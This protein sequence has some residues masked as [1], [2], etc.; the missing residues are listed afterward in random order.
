MTTTGRRATPTRGLV[1]GCGGTLG[2]AWTTGA[3]H[4][5][6]EALRWDPRDAD[7]V[8][9][10]SAGAELAAM[11]GSGIGVRD[12]LA[13]Q[14][15][16]EQA[17]PALLRHFATPPRGIPPRPAALLGSPRL[18][19]RALGG[20]LPVLTGLSGLLPRGRGDTARLAA[21]ADFLAPDGQ[22]VAHPATWLV[23]TDFD[24]GRRTPF[25]HPGTPPVALRDALRASWA[26]P[27]WFPPVRIDGRRYA[28]GGISSPTSAD[29]LVP[30][31][32]DEVYVVAPMSSLS[33]GRRSGLG[34]AEAVLRRVMTRILSAECA[35][36][37]AAGTR[38]IR[39]EPTA[40]DLRA[41]G[42]NLMDG[43][44]R[45]AVLETSLRTTRALVRDR[46]QQPVPRPRPRTGA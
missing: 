44:R 42:G 1:L 35:A 17:P 27:G 15:A 36:L 39:I 16:G 41:M 32:L 9:G 7:V 14:L 29:L 11:L 20:A 6:Q 24:T 45:P 21:V 43:R 25:G 5:L 19:R 38:V 23:A 31:G 18:A 4:S 40:A 34:R 33:P 10:T 22:W 30:C 28:D 2:A 13:A 26:V 12:L 3:L 46:L 8:V 37:S